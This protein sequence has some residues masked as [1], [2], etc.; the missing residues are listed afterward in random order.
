MSDRVGPDALCMSET[1]QEGPCAWGLRQ[2]CVLLAGEA[3][4]LGGAEE[5]HR[6]GSEAGLV[7]ARICPGTAHKCSGGC[8]GLLLW[9]QVTCNSS[10]QLNFY[11]E[12]RKLG[13]LQTFDT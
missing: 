4:K 13:A 11:I 1:P 8:F 9:I 5:I 7:D 6:N 3:A 2:H 12:L 10:L